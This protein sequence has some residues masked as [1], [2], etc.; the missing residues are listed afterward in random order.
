MGSGVSWSRPEGIHLTLKFLGDVEETQ[1]ASIAESV[2]IAAQAC[3][4]FSLQVD[5]TG[6]F[7]DFRRPRVYW[8]GVKEPTGTLTELQTR[9]E[10]ELAKLGFAKEKRAF[11]AHLTL[12]RVKSTEKIGRI[13]TQLQQE[14][15]QFGE[16]ITNEITVMQ[17][18]LQPSGAVYT[19][20]QRIPLQG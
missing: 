9:I 10:T 4:P 5:G 8:V 18:Q 1:V 16:F 20:L 19:P 2:R 12:G 11:S 14:T 6:A 13:S 3:A 15:P 17:S 7:P